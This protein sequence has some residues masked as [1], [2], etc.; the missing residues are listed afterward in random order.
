MNN[1]NYLDLLLGE[2]N[3]KNQTAK[4]MAFWCPRTTNPAHV[5]LQECALSSAAQFK[6]GSLLKIKSTKGPAFAGTLKTFGEW[7]AIRYRL[8]DGEILKFQVKRASGGSIKAFCNFYIQVRAD[9]ANTEVRFPLTCQEKSINAFAYIRGNFD[10]LTLEEAKI[11]G[12]FCPPAFDAIGHKVRVEAAIQVIELEKA[13]QLKPSLE[14]VQVQSDTESKNDE[15][16]VMVKPK[17]VIGRR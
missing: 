17:H 5:G 1:Q 14:M 4:V 3:L 11:Q 13:R 6:F 9:A 16:I 12:V 2:E 10:I 15:Q 8:E 7:D